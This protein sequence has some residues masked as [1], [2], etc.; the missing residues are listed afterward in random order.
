MDVVF[1][2][3]LIDFYQRLQSVKRIKQKMRVHLILQNLITCHQ[4]FSDKALVFNG[5][6]TA[7]II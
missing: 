3:F 1:R 7:S 2:F 4:I 6:F 5:D